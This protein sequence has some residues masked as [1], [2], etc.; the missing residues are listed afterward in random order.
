MPFLVSLWKLIF[1]KEEELRKCLDL[2]NCLN[3]KIQ[4]FLFRRV[5]ATAFSKL[6]K[7]T[8]QARKLLFVVD[9]ITWKMSEKL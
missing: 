4:N 7:G 5:F 6:V 8:D 1:L 2:Q 9:D 3:H